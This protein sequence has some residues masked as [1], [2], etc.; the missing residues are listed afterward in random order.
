[1]D[2]VFK[3]IH[4]DGSETVIKQVRSAFR[5]EEGNYQEREETVTSIF[6][7]SSAGCPF[8]CV[9][10]HLTEMGMKFKKIEIDQI[11]ENVLEAVDECEFG[12]A[13]S[14]YKLC[15]MGMGDPC[16]DT[17]KTHE[18]IKDL[19]AI[20]N[21]VE[22]D[23][24][25]VRPRNLKWLETLTETVNIRLFY[26]LHTDVLRHLIV[27][28]ADLHA[29]D[30]IDLKLWSGDLFIH[31]TP[32]EGLNDGLK[33]ALS[34][35][36]FTKEFKAKQVRMLEFNPYS[37]SV[38]ERPSQEQLSKLY[39]LF[40]KNNVDVKWQVSKGKEELAACGQFHD[41]K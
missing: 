17:W 37:D 27:P 1:M 7:S 26:S 32:V 30:M 34:I 20:L 40:K 39:R 14:F 31:Y 33:D 6:I 3:K 29:A 41:N 2:K 19:T 36:K 23:V 11:V 5:D 15:F 16:V 21:V 35:I 4:G 22:V 18:V 8:K 9:F 38:Y 28:D 12:G 10:C 13:E 24:S 25:T